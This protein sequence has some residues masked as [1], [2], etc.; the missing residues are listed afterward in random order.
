MKKLLLVSCLLLFL[1]VGC[2]GIAACNKTKD[3]PKTFDSGI[4]KM[5]KAGYEVTVKSSTEHY[6][7]FEAVKGGEYLYAEL[8]TN[9][10]QAQAAQELYSLSPD[11]SGSYSVKLENL[12]VYFGTDEAIGDFFD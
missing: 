6:N 7:C 11:L 2:A 10:G 4:D 8:C 12:W 9:I 3:C 1:I 5:K